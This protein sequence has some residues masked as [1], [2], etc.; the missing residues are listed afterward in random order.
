[1]VYKNDA[2]RKD[3][4]KKKKK[5]CQTSIFQTLS[6]TSTL[7]INFQNQMETVPKMGRHEIY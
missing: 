3:T 2:V 6:L 1:M 5:N 7:T 4:E